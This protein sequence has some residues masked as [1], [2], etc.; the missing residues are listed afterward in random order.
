MILD[1][2]PTFNNHL[3][4]NPEKVNRDIRVIRKPQYVLPRATLITKYKSF[5]RPILY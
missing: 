1:Y 3:E 2:R 5:V 4:K